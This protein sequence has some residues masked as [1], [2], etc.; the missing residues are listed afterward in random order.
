MKR[1]SWKFGWEVDGL[2]VNDK[3]FKQLET[4]LVVS[5]KTEHVWPDKQAIIW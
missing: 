5:Y 4:S 1:H 3:I 2:S